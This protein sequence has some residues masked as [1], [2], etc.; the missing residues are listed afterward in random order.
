M[1]SRS[2]LW[3]QG[4]PFYRFNPHLNEEISP[5][6]TNLEKLFNLI[7]QT[8]LQTEGPDMKELVQLFHLVAE[9]SRKMQAR[10]Y[11]EARA[12]ELYRTF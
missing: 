1:T 6:E 11:C 8:R 9:M 12:E 5:A 7:I 4:V 3:D 2:R 10:K